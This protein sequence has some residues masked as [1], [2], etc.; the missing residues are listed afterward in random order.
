MALDIAVIRAG[1]DFGPWT[2][3]AEIGDFLRA[4]IDE[5]ND[6]LHLRM[7]FHDGVRD[8]VEQGRLARP[9]RRNNQTALSHAERR[10]QIHDAR[11]VAVRDRL[12]LDLAIRVDRRQ[13][14]EWPQP[15]ILRRLFAVDLIE[16]NQL[17]A[18][19]PAAGLA[20]NPHAV[21]QREAPNDFR[22]HKNIVRRL[23]EIPFRV[24]E[25]TK[26]FA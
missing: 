17:R 14:L 18:A 6:E 9:R 4:L 15:L 13:L 25:K 16:A 26:P 24:A 19:V 20:V 2:G 21:A 5:K 12:E 1:H 3:A 22:R 11:G 10:H 23:D 7:I 8:V